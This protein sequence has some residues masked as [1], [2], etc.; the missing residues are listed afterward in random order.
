MEMKEGGG[1]IKQTD[2]CSALKTILA[3]FDH[4]RRPALMLKQGLTRLGL[5]LEKQTEERGHKERRVEIR[6][7][8]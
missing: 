2:I 4:C 1:I 3:V 6:S 5:C 8:S 7:K